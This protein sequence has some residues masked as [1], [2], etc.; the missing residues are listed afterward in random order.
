M[1][2][3]NYVHVIRYELP[4]LTGKGKNGIFKLSCQTQLEKRSSSVLFSQSL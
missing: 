4:S 2:S 1:L 3:H